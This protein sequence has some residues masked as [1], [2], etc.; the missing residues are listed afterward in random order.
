MH[1]HIVSIA[2]LAAAMFPAPVF[3]EASADD[4]AE[5]IIAAGGVTYAAAHFVRYAPRTALD[6][7]RQIPGFVIAEGESR[8]GLGQGG[9]NVLINGQRISGKSVD[10]VSALT[11]ISASNV[12][13][14]DLVD[15]AS[16]D[17]PGLSGRVVNIVTNRNQLSGQVRW[18]PQVR[19]RLTKARLFDGEATLNGKLGDIDFSLA[20]ANA[21]ERWGNSGFEY[22]YDTAGNLIDRRYE[23]LLI[24]RDEPRIT[25]TL[26]HSADNGNIANLSGA[27][28][29]FDFTLREDSDRVDLVRDFRN[30]EREHNY[31]LSG[32]YE[33]ALL[34]GRL[35]LI[36]LHRFE[37]SPLRSQVVFDYDDV[38]SSDGSRFVQKADETEW[39]ARA[40][41]GWKAGSA[42][43]QLS[44]EV[45]FN[46]LDV[47]AEFARLDPSGDFVTVP[48]ANASATVKESRGEVAL[49]YARPLG[50]T[51]SLQSSIG[52]EYSQLRQTGP[53]GLTRTF[54]RPK[55][56]VSLSWKASDRLDLR[57][58][59]ERKVGQ[60]NF[61]DFVAST[62]IS[63]GNSDA[64]N[65]NLVPEQSW[66]FEVGATRKLGAFGTA[67]AK[68]Y[69][70]LVSD[71]VDVVPIGDSGESPGNV[72]KATVW[73]I[74]WNSTFNFDAF[75]WSGARLD[76]DLA[77]RKS[78]LDDPLTGRPRRISEEQ[79]YNLSAEFRHD[80]P[81]TDWAYGWSMESPRF[82][83]F[84]RLGEIG[85]FTN[86]PGVFGVFLE[87]KNIA[88]LKATA[89]ANNLLGT[90]EGLD[91]TIYVG[92]RDGP[93]LVRED[94]KRFYGPVFTLDI[95]GSF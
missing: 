10:A 70:R 90:N 83:R 65:P 45:A 17:V 9:D 87:H 40:E 72:D 57:A 88:G 66:D 48:L 43:W 94:R 74:E 50:T 8:R 46:R 54:W 6:M 59:V 11:R 44:G 3:A 52:A 63:A 35:K 31:E 84:V 69:A 13:R 18:S 67:T 56:F 21:S 86:T 19:T 49:S 79:I 30:T 14:I 68:A 36:G 34:G 82:A 58:R 23:V 51:L 71:I 76:L 26:K 20:L 53:A 75:G 2:A 33:F 15:A 73:G 5:A 77:Y 32:D 42:D 12:A 81:S 28:A 89:R 1:L 24:D 60:L 93:A 95:S 39:I 41:Y 78:R 7:V 4:A 16:L 91:R 25:A 37:H 27:F 92:R 85:R 64:G 61:F 80:I 47:D 29:R 62:D 55:G 22:V 38:R